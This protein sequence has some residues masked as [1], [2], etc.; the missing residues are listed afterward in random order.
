MT[1]KA[2]EEEE[3]EQTLRI[4]QVYRLVSMEWLEYIRRRERRKEEGK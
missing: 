3:E 4:D 2:Q 1:L